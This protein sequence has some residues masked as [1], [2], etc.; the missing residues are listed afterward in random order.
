MYI[1]CNILYLFHISLNMTSLVSKEIDEIEFAKI[2]LNTLIQEWVERNIHSILEYLKRYPIL[3]EEKFANEGFKNQIFTVFWSE[4]DIKRFPD[5]QHWYCQNFPF[6]IEMTLENKNMQKQI[7]EKIPSLI[8]TLTKVV[9]YN[10]EDCTK[11]T[12]DRLSSLLSLEHI[13]KSNLIWLKI[14]EDNIWWLLSALTSRAYSRWGAG[15]RFKRVYDLV[16]RSGATDLQIWEGLYTWRANS[17]YTPS[18]LLQYPEFPKWKLEEKEE[19]NMIRSIF[20]DKI[21]YRDIDSINDF[22]QIYPFIASY[23]DLAKLELSKVKKNNTNK[24]STTTS[25]LMNWLEWWYKTV[26]AQGDIQKINA[27]KEIFGDIIASIDRS[28][29]IDW[30]Y[31][32]LWNFIWYDWEDKIEG[33]YEK[34][35]TV[36]Q[37]IPLTE[38]EISDYILKNPTKLPWIIDF[39]PWYNFDGL[40]KD[41]KVIDCFL[42]SIKFYNKKVIQFILDHK[43]FTK[44]QLDDIYLI[45]FKEKLQELIADRPYGV[46]Q[47]INQLWVVCYDK[48]K[49]KEALQTDEYKHMILQ[50]VRKNTWYHWFE[51]RESQYAKPTYNILE[52]ELFSL[53]QEEIDQQVISKFIDIC[54]YG[55]T[56]YMVEYSQCV[57][58]K[59]N[60]A[61]KELKDSCIAW[62]LYAL[63]LWRYESIHQVSN[64]TSLS[65]FLYQFPFKKEILADQWVQVALS[66][67]KI[68]FLEQW[69]ISEIKKIDELISH[70]S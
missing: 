54:K 21:W 55:S 18:L 51:D 40:Y 32:Q 19:H 50:L 15:P 46:I 70:H 37:E 16:K 6:L 13:Y 63:N 33:H 68:H 39:F 30:V 62:T 9:K 45:N 35:Q 47:Y 8:D 31:K 25:L 67:L 4:L 64:L 3:Q 27:L 53:S 20:C 12:D 36:L 41:Q 59:I 1:I 69:W 29:V 58:D 28:R 44:E 48:K 42:L 2:W 56:T 52:H 43:I 24:Y 7:S 57:K 10:D 22:M 26:L 11:Y 34:I 49:I 60:T 14:K 17:W 23:I 66:N 61:D 5:S 65:L 38:E